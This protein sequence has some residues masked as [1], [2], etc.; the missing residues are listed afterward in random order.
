MTTIRKAKKKDIPY[1]NDLLKQVCA[2]HSQ[3]RPDLFK[4]NAKK[5]TNAQLAMLLASP[6]NYIFVAE[7]N[8]IVVAYCFCERQNRGGNIFYDKPSLYIDDL[9]VDQNYRG[10]KIG[11]SIFKHVQN[12]AKENG[13]YDI[14]LNVWNLNK[15]AIKFYEKMGLKP[16]KIVLEKIL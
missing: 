5:Y 15:G 12:F 14:T 7:L 16:L 2:V 10:Q 3:G 1:L 13:F 4:Q 6:N 8:G 11:E 9:C